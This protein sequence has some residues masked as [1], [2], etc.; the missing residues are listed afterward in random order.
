MVQM[1]A[2]LLSGDRSTKFVKSDLSEGFAENWLQK[3]L[4][5]ERELLP[6]EQVEPGAGKFIPVCGELP[7]PKSGGTVFLDVFGVTS[8]GRPVLVE[9]KLWRNPQARREVIAQIL[10]Y[11]ALLRGWSY[12]DL[13]ARLKAKL[14]WEG[15]NPLYT[16]AAALG[17]LLSE[18]D[19]T[20]AVSRNLRNGD[21]HLIVAGDGI[22]EDAQAI[23]EHIGDK[24][25]RIAL[26]EFQRWEDSEGNRLIVPSV[27]FRTTV[28]R[29][30]ILVDAEGT[31]LRVSSDEEIEDEVRAEI[32]PEKVAAITA[33]RSFWDRFIAETRFDHPEQPPPRHGGNNWVKIG[34]PSPARW[35]TAY[36]SRGRAGLFLVE[37]SG[38][39]LIERLIA[40]APSI[41]EEFGPEPLRLHQGNDRGLSAFA[42]DEPA[43]ITDQMQWLRDASN[44]LVNALRPRLVELGRRE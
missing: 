8:A 32:D 20:D 19:F 18:A 26:V 28:V 17:C 30:R 43:G 44:R 10:E 11:A 33:N 31:A 25:A 21:F 2:F 1:S 27:P 40:E 41:Q 35:L 15:A 23:A 34:L 36:R 14:G 12:A 9:C 42:V 39:G 29:Q 6:L 22:R 37:E 3:F 5:R 16:Q 7:L 38:S 24:G 13:T 4:L